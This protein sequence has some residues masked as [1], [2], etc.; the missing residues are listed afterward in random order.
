M[1][2]PVRVSNAFTRISAPCSDPSEQVR[3]LYYYRNYGYRLQSRRGLQ[4]LP[5]TT[6]KTVSFKRVNA[7]A[8]IL[9]RDGNIFS[10]PPALRIGNRSRIGRPA[11]GRFI[12]I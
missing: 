8:M 4:S 9:Q 11:G 12:V 1:P 6:Q 5:Q 2:I 7:A 10:P 3:N